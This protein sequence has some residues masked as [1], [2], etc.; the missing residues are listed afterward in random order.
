MKAIAAH[1]RYISKNGRLEIEDDRGVVE[2]GKEAVKD[3]ERQWQFGGAYIGDEGHRREAFNV[4]LSMPRG[5]RSADRPEGR[6]RVRQDRVRRPPLRDGAARPPGQSARAP[7]R[8]GRV[9][10]RSAA[11]PEEGRPAPLA[12]NVCRAAARVGRRCR[13]DAA[14]HPRGRSQLPGSL[15][16]EGGRGG[17]GARGATGAKGWARP[18]RQVAGVQD[19]LGRSLPKRCVH[20]RI[21]AINGSLWTSSAS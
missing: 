5:H 2:R 20:H 6:A 15:A 14:G 12:R 17:Q 3:I 4:M 10:A 18:P 11:Q 9:Q 13:G 7:E 19:R 1:F 21:R 16:Q 8:Q